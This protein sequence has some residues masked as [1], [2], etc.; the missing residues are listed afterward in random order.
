MKSGMVVSGL[1]V[2]KT[3]SHL[4]STNFFLNLVIWTPSICRL[5]YEQV[6]MIILWSRIGRDRCVILQ[7]LTRSTQTNRRTDR[8]TNQRSDK[9]AYRVRYWK[10][11]L[12]PKFLTHQQRHSI[13]THFP[14]F[15]PDWFE[16]GFLNFWL[17]HY[18]NELNLAHHYYNL[19]FFILYNLG[20]FILVELPKKKNRVFCQHPVDPMHPALPILP[21]S[22]ECARKIFYH[23]HFSPLMTPDVKWSDDTSRHSSAT[24]AFIS[25]RRF[26][27]FYH[28]KSLF[29]NLFMLRVIWR[30]FLR[31]RS[32]PHLWNWGSHL[33]LS[34]LTR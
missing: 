32:F 7:F 26:A 12:H 11:T 29:S 20:L 23:V 9:A 25:D 33:F 1:I 31:L 5:N 19:G 22:N 17:H 10:C 3:V 21:K 28:V 15:W 14:P 18:K 8:R 27:L 16:S 4:L 13:L 6:S 34:L 24:S 30:S 2:I